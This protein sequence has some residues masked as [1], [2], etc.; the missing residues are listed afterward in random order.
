MRQPH[1]LPQ[2]LPQQP[3]SSAPQSRPYGRDLPDR[4]HLDQL[5]HQA[6]EL[7]RSA[8]SGNPDALRRLA[9]V[10]REPSLSGAQLA[11][12][13]EFGFPSW[14][15]LKAEVDRRA[16]HAAQ[17]DPV[18]PVPEVAA[19][20]PETEFLVRPVRSADELALALDVVGAQFDPP[21][22]REDRRFAEL[23]ARF[24]EDRPLMFVAEA[25]G[26]IVGG[27]L[28]VRPNGGAVTVRAIALEPH[29]RRQGLGRRLMQ[30]VELAALRIGARGINLGAEEDARVFYQRLGYAGRG[31]MMHKG[32]PLPG[33]LLEA[34][35]RKLERELI[36]DTAGGAI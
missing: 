26:A 23:A 12:A 13:R 3:D 8:Q 9:A 4:P 25:G 36:P 30:A 7:Q 32:L 33:R 5:R 2:P 18:S 11:I 20:E 16:S 15:R 10:S 1:S 34:R 27:A 22:S 6:R 24:E 17:A 35:L 14:E 21:I 29:A 28:A 31:A 19:G